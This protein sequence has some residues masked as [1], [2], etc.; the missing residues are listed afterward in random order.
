[1]TKRQIVNILNN[2]NGIFAKEYEVDSL[3]SLRL[4]EERFK[5][6]FRV[7]KV[8][9]YEDCSGYKGMITYQILADIRITY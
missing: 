9:F 8:E 6:P 2:H 3:E 4:I 5:F 7:V 1:M